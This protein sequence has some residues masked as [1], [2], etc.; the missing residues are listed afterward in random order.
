L[1]GTTRG[2]ITATG[3]AVVAAVAVMKLVDRGVVDLDKPLVTYLPAFRM[4]S[5][6]YEN[7]TVRMLL[8]HSTGF[9]GTDG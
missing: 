1:R 2:P 6:G 7:V 8:S 3:D 5:A 9:P 4:A